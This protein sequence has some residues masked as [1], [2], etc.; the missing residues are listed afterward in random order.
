MRVWC[1]KM[2]RIWG[3]VVAGFG[4]L[5]AAL[6]FVAGQR[7]RAR[8]SAARAKAEAK[9][10]EIVQEVEREIDKAKAQAREKSQEVQREADERPEG[11]RPK[12]YFRR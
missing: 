11:E 2:T 8:E 7:N 4:L 10:R 5:G 3:W 9:G 12:G 6:L 1:L